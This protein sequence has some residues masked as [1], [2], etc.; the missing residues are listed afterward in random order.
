L[1][2]NQPAYS[3]FFF[4]PVGSHLQRDS[5]AGLPTFCGGEIG[6]REEGKRTGPFLVHFFFFFFPS[7]TPSS[8]QRGFPD[9]KPRKIIGPESEVDFVARWFWITGTGIGKEAWLNNN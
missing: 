5:Q 9:S 3:T 8:G 7:P 6:R 2:V 4:F 1:W